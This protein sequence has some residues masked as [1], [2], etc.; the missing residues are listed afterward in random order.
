MNMITI[1]KINS[2]LYQLCENLSSETA[3][4][5]YLVIGEE[6]AALVDSG[7]GVSGNLYEVIRTVTDKPVICLLTH[8]DPDHAGAAALF[9]KI[10]MSEEERPLLE[11]G[12]IDP[13]VRLLTAKGMSGNEKRSACFKDHMVMA[14]TFEFKPIVDGQV[15]EL[16]K[17]RLEAIWVPGHTKGSMCFW[18]RDENYCLSGDAVINGTSPVLVFKKCLSMESYKENLL[19]LRAKIGASCHLYSGHNSDRIEPKLLEEILVLC[20][21]ILDG[22]TKEDSTYLPPF[23]N[24]LLNSVPPEKQMVIKETN[25]GDGVPVEH[26]KIGFTASVKY[27]AAKIRKEQER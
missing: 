8:S 11:N 12:S 15:F 1:R 3:V 22:K 19:K 18:N 25:F 6:T 13:T 9:D 24:E 17:N 2:R 10:Y 5:M 21:E 26:K 27:N 16:G 23:I 7:F 14:D 4:Y 20:D